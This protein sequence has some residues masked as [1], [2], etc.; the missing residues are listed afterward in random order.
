MVCHKARFLFLRKA[1]FYHLDKMTI[2]NNYL[3]KNNGALKKKLRQFGIS[4]LCKSPTSISGQTYAVSSL[5]LNWS[6]CKLD[7]GTERDLR[8]TTHVECIPKVKTS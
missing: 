2:G 8:M 4:L 5:C 7:L 6:K 3:E 1:Y